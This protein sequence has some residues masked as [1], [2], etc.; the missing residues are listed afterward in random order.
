METVAL[1]AWSSAPSDDEIRRS[2]AGHLCRC[3][4]HPRILRAV[5]RAA[6]EAAQ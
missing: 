5:R 3:G 2:H 6:R 4:A 1:L